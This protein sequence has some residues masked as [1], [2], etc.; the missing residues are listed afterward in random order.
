VALHLSFSGIS[1]E[2]TDDTMGI[3]QLPKNFV[4]VQHVA[5]FFQHCA[6]HFVGKYFD[7]G[8][9]HSGW[10]SILINATVAERISPFL[11]HF[12]FSHP[13]YMVSAI[14]A[15]QVEPRSWLAKIP[16][17]FWGLRQAVWEQVRH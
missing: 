7:G 11:W 9:K 1:F 12:C 3:V 5:V 15:E 16:V 10:L 2:Q 17:Y 13:P 14:P 4:Q 8:L 6:L